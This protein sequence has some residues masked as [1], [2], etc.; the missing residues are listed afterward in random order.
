[1]KRAILTAVAAVALSIVAPVAVG[2]VSAHSCGTAADDRTCLDKSDSTIYV[3]NSNG[4]LYGSMP[5]QIGCLTLSVGVW[6]NSV[7]WGDSANSTRFSWGSGPA[8]SCG[9]AWAG[10]WGTTDFGSSSVNSIRVTNAADHNVLEWFANCCSTH[11]F[12]VV[13]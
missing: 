5:V 8:G 1:M 6:A 9:G 11:Q 4:S 2:A 13:N 7:W 3:F 10:Q 12:Q